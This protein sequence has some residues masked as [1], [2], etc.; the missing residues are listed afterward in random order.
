M[1]GAGGTSEGTSGAE[2][3]HPGREGECRILRSYQCL[4]SE[5]VPVSLGGPLFS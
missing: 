4:W 5:P 2:G 3:G 1:G